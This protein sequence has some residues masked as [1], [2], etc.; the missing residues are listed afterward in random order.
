MSR[1]ETP[2]ADGFL[3]SNASLNSGLF[4]RVIQEELRDVD[5][6]EVPPLTPMRVTTDQDRKVV[7]QLARLINIIGD[8]VK[9][10]AELRE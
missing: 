9:D 3:E 2:S 1:G 4:R 5:S 7:T 10:D 8:R 6:V